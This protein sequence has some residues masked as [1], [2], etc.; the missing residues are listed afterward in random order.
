VIETFFDRD[1]EDA[2]VHFQRWRARHWADG[3]FVNYKSPNDVM[4]HRSPCP[5]LG[6]T[7]WV[8]FEQGFGSLT[9]NKKICSTD[10]PEL[11]RWASKNV[12]AD[13]KRFRDCERL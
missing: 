4:L 8:R 2:H 11:E 1:E 9:R 12:A 13:L 7:D 3:Y 10:R 5:H 6:D